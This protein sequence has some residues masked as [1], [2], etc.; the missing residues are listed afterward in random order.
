MRHRR[1]VFLVLAVAVATAVFAWAAR[2]PA[3]RP[4]IA[5]RFE[6]DTNGSAD[7]GRI[8][9]G[10]A[11]EI[12]RLLAQIDGLDVRATVRAS[13]QTDPRE[14]THVSSLDRSAGFVLQGLVLVDAGAVRQ[15]HAS[16]ISTSRRT[17]LWSRHFRARNNDI[18]AVNKAIVAAV[19]EAR[20]DSRQHEPAAVQRAY[21][22]A[23]QRQADGGYNSLW[24]PTGILQPRFAT[25]TVT[26]DF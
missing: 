17:P 8:A 13:R 11:I 14:N 19:A 22:A 18:F 12:T 9:D 23:Q 2:G 6:Y 24:V 1:G 10:I 16:L 3:T 21:A 26:L 7:D 5:V 15:I 4:S 20:S 25:F